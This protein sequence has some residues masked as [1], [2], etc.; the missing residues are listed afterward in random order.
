MTLALIQTTTLGSNTNTISLS[1][2]PSTYKDLYLL[3]NARSSTAGD[4]ISIDMTFNSNTSSLYSLARGYASEGG[5]GAQGLTAQ[6]A[7]AVGG[8]SGTNINTNVFSP[9]EIYIFDYA[10]GAYTT[11]KIVS[12]QLSTGSGTFNIIA[13]HFGFNSTTVVSSIQIKSEAGTNFAAG[14]NVSLYGIK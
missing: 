12:S 4:R 6:T 14:S 5:P 2:I 3:L 13:S 9:A 11:G 7:I 10:N 8:M 1:S